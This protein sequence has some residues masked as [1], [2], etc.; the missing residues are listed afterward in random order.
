M[1]DL[2]KKQ[3]EQKIRKEITN[4]GDCE[5]I[6]NA[7]L[8]TLDVN[9]SYNTIRRLFGLATYTKPNKKTLDILSKFL[10]YKNYFHFSQNAQYK[11]K[12]EFQNDMYKVIYHNDIEAITALIKNRKVNQQNY[13]GFIAQLSRE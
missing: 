7:I 1:I 12:T 6:S 11:E 10:G 13:S 9:I 8:Q 3:I 5:M 2:L 4:R